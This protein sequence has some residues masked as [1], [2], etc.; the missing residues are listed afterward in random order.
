MCLRSLRIFATLRETSF[1]N[2]CVSKMGSRKDAKI[3][4]DRNEH[5]TSFSGGPAYS[6]MPVDRR[7]SPN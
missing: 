2:A 7:R 5:Q 1:F 6:A 3:R 4:K